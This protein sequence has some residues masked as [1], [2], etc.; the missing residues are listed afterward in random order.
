MLRRLWKDWKRLAHRIG[1]FQARV[2]L[3][4]MYAVLILPFG[5]AVR[6]FSDTLRIKK[7]PTQWVDRPGEPTEIN[8]AHKQW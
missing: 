6:F 4:A 3:T 2:M 1:D 8:W 7:R 5:L